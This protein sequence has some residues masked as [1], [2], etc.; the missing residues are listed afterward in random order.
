MFKPDIRR[1]LEIK[2]VED[3]ETKRLGRLYMKVIDVE[4]RIISRTQNTKVL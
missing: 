2:G 1:R 4:D 3:Q